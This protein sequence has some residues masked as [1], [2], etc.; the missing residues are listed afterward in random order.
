[1]AGVLNY[2]RYLNTLQ[3]LTEV[4]NI[5]PGDQKTYTFT[6]GGSTSTSTQGWTAT[7][8][9]ETLVID[10]MVY[11]KNN[12]PDFT[13]S[14][15]LGI[16]TG[17]TISQY[18]TGTILIPANMYT[19]P[20][21]PAHT[22]NV[23]VTVVN[24]AWTKDGDIFANNI[25]YIQ[26]WE[27][28]VAINDPATGD[29][30]E[31]VVSEP[32]T[33]ILTGPGGIVYQRSIELK[34]QTDIPLYLGTTTR[35]YFYWDKAGG[36]VLLGIAYFDPNT[37]IATLN[38]STTGT[39]FTGG[40][41]PIYAETNGFRQY[42]FARSN[43]LQQVVYQHIPLLWV[44]ESRT[45]QNPSNKYLV[46]EEFVF[47]QTFQPDPSYPQTGYPVSNVVRLYVVTSRGSTNYWQKQ[48]T[49]TTFTNGVLSISYPVTLDGFDTQDTND[50]GGYND[51]TSLSTG[52]LVGNTF[53]CVISV[54][55][56][57]VFNTFWEVDLNGPYA[58]GQR[59]GG[60]SFTAEY[61]TPP[62]TITGE[63]YP[64]TL[65][66]DVST[67]FLTENT[68]FRVTR[69]SRYH[70]GYIKLMG[71]KGSDAFTELGSFTNTGRQFGTTT[72]EPLTI[73]TLTTGTW[74]LYAS[75]AGDLG[76]SYRSE[77][78]NLAS[79]SNT[80][81]HFITLGQDLPVI[82]TFQ[83]TASYDVVRAVATY[84]FSDT[85]QMPKYVSFYQ[86]GSLINT[87]TWVRS[88]S[89]SISYNTS[90]VYD[91]SDVLLN[92]FVGSLRGWQN[93][94]DFTMF[95]YKSSTETNSSYL[96]SPLEPRTYYPAATWPPTY[97]IDPDTGGRYE[98][99]PAGS[100]PPYAMM[101]SSQGY[102]VIALQR[103]IDN[104]FPR[105]MY[106]D[107]ASA[108]ITLTGYIGQYNTTMYLYTISR[109]LPVT[110]QRYATQISPN[111]PTFY[112][113]GKPPESLG[114]WGNVYMDTNN[115]TVYVK[116]Q[117]PAPS[118]TRPSG[119]WYE[120]GF[121]KDFYTDFT[122]SM[123]FGIKRWVAANPSNATQVNN[124]AYYNQVST[125]LLNKTIGTL[126]TVTLTTPTIFTIYRGQHVAELKLPIGTIY[127]ADVLRATWLGTLDLD[128]N[129]GKLNPFDIGAT[130][131]PSNAEILPLTMAT[132]DA[133]INPFRA[134]FPDS[135]YWGNPTVIS[136]TETSYIFSTNPVNLKV[137]V[138]VENGGYGGQDGGT[139]TFYR[140]DTNQDIG[141]A[142]VTSGT[143]VL[144]ITA[145][146]IPGISAGTTTSITI[147]AR[148][149]GALS[150]DSTAT[151]FIT[152]NVVKSA[153]DM[154]PYQFSRYMK[155]EF[156]EDAGVEDGVDYHIPVV[157]YIAPTILKT[158]Y[159]SDYPAFQTPGRRVS[160]YGSYLNVEHPMTS[161]RG[162]C[163][164]Y[165]NQ[166]IYGEAFNRSGYWD[167]TSSFYFVFRYT[168]VGGVFNGQVG[169]FVPPNFSDKFNNIC[170]YVRSDGSPNAGPG[171]AR[172]TLN[173]IIGR[174]SGNGSGNFVV[175]NFGF[176][177]LFWTDDWT[178]IDIDFSVVGIDFFYQGI[179]SMSPGVKL[180]M[181][182]S[183]NIT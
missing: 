158:I 65:T 113:A 83:R 6:V 31:P 137:A 131:P 35:C 38:Y 170:S 111:T 149:N 138:T 146:D 153:L 136:T 164:A 142:T 178:R 124:A 106:I 16:Y 67:S 33:L 1:M 115:G 62:K 23:P 82:L 48:L 100:S 129:F 58:S 71:R 165:E 80:V 109:V 97:A 85:R 108:F 44:S 155:N 5:F 54:K 121:S 125:G 43:T 20:I 132:V 116:R 34:A 9:W 77:S 94:N 128:R 89:T 175:G 145:N 141:T 169:W 130:L 118:T 55:N 159:R 168:V 13:D 39:Q 86:G 180:G 182:S 14:K 2:Q 88:T 79:T 150:A 19:G 152:A 181:T 50:W 173:T 156:G 41:Y 93:P 123:V 114:T 99:T 96:A 143:G 51:S 84:N 98:V 25:A 133:H 166:D 176:S 8:S 30:Y 148:F 135:P 61:L 154:I 69:P 112:G 3:T 110:G 32:S 56:F 40:T 183:W 27:P 45:P 107:Q 171:P 122:N 160:V 42:G 74:T 59:L 64:I 47:S 76:T 11:D 75:F 60:G 46:G 126:N 163:S 81:T 66:Q 167:R 87:A 37:N 29:G 53:T 26:N 73:D 24:I 104:S 102:N 90:T 10:Q 140:V 177:T 162:I 95:R 151:N 17:T 70:G 117:Y 49:T 15:V 21:L 144:S 36:R 91:S 105:T 18:T 134:A 92:S 57:F 157:P 179:A 139:V 12:R 103:E 119:R 147:G 174:T 68:T 78:K 172:Y 161:F 72:S 7:V 22:V 127:N 63:A 52:T 28:G 101:G 4:G 120:S